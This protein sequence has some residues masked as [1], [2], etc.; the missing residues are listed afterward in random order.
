ML[1]AHTWKLELLSCSACCSRM[2]K[3]GASLMDAI[4]S[5]S[6]EPLLM[7]R[8]SNVRKNDLQSSMDAAIS[9]KT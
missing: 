3:S 9:G 7:L 5:I 8:E 6:A 2:L 4:F 1:A